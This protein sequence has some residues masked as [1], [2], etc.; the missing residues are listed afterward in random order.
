MS[1]VDIEDEVSANDTKA[2]DVSELKKLPETGGQTGNRAK[3]KTDLAEAE[4][5]D[6]TTNPNSDRI[7][8]TA[9]Y[10]LTASAATA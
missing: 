6:D 1:L 2:E 4:D 7:A 10:Q 9:L 5:G 3:A 8:A